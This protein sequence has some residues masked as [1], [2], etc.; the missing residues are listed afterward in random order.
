MQ[1]APTVDVNGARAS[2]SV[3]LVD[4]SP[5]TRDALGALIEASLD[6]T[7]VR[8][9]PQTRRFGDTVASIS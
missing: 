7:V 2:L 4:A 1:P 3:L 8:H 9:N 6:A 5:L